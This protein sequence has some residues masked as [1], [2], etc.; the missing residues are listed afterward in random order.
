MTA[1][2]ET[3]RESLPEA[4]RDLKVNLQQALGESTLT[5]AQRWGTALACA[6]ASRNRALTQAILDAAREHVDAATVEDARA[7]AALMAMNNVY[8]RF[9]HMLPGGEY[10]RMPARLRMTRLARTQGPKLDFE[11]FCLAVSA[12]FGCPSC[13]VAHERSIREAGGNAE[14]IHDAVRV[15]AIIHGVAVG[16]ELGN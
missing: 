2:L 1:A 7:A 9:K 12:V 10:E 14:Q 16:L 13:V 8:Y 5:T 4:A 6:V 3:L 15:A 11:L